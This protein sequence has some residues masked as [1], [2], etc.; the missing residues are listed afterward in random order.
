LLQLDEGKLRNVFELLG[1]TRVKAR[2]ERIFNLIASGQLFWRHVE[3]PALHQILGID[4]SEQQRMKL[5]MA[6]LSAK[7]NRKSRQPKAEIS[8][9]MKIS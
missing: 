8:K 7:L 5:V 4:R 1:E 3:E 9:A 6:R 2:A